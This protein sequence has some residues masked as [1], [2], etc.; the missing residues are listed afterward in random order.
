M[1]T[2]TALRSGSQSGGYRRRTPTL[3]FEGP[4]SSNTSAFFAFVTG[5]GVDPSNDQGIWVERSGSPELVVRSGD[6]APGT[7]G[8]YRR[9]GVLVQGE[10]Q[11]LLS[12]ASLR[13]FK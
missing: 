10:G 8:P 1:A 13:R 5:E 4:S 3:S 7:S 9:V 6:P 12:P 2:A 11:P